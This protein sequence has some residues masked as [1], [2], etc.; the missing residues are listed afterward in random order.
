M[1]KVR[2]RC[3]RESELLDAPVMERAPPFTDA[4]HEVKEESAMLTDFESESVAD[5]TAPL[6]VSERFVNVHPDMSSEASEEMEKRE[7]EREVE[8]DGDISTDV[9]VSVPDVAD[10]SE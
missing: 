4:V 1:Q 5:K 6:P 10:A 7:E 3:V 2:E 9:I 8:V